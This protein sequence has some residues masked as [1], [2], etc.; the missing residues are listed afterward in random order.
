MSNQNAEVFS[1][2][3]KEAKF[4]DLEQYTLF[5]ETPD[6]PG[7]RSRMNFGERNGAPR[8][9]V[10]TGLEEGP[11][12][13][14]VGFSPAVF[15][16]FLNQFTEITKAPPGTALKIDNMTIDP[17]VTIDKNTNLDN[18][19]KVVKNSLFFGKDQDGVCWIGIEQKGVKNIRFKIL[20]SA[21]HRFYHQDGTPVSPEEMSARFTRSLISSLRRAMDRW[22]SRIRPAWEPDPSRGKG[23]YKPKDQS[24]NMGTSADFGEDITY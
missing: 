3:N 2:P 6:R 4:H 16:E 11:G 15:E 14:A 19:A 18:V 20:P 8:I 24:I 21:W 9:T 22:T 7:W 5:T 23:N 17:T 10:M 12:V 1:R 13:V